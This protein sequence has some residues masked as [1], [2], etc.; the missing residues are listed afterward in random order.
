MNPPKKLPSNIR[1]ACI[2]VNDAHSQ[3]LGLNSTGIVKA[4]KKNIMNQTLN[5]R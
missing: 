4:R 5:H 3:F 2:T 1:G